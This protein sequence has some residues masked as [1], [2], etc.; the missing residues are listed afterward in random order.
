MPWRSIDGKDI[1]PQGKR[2]LF[3]NS[4]VS[5]IETIKKTELF[6]QILKINRECIGV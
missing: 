6:P 5:L 2:I 4:L 3:V 1:I